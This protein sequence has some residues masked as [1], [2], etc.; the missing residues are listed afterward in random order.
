MT[1]SL[2]I[3]WRIFDPFNKNIVSSSI[4]SNR[5][6]D[7]WILLVRLNSSIWPAKLNLSIFI[8]FQLIRNTSI[9]CEYTTRVCCNLCCRTIFVFDCP[10]INEQSI[11]A[12]CPIYFWFLAELMILSSYG[13]SS[14]G[15]ALLGFFL[16]VDSYSPY[17]CIY[18]LGS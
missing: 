13:T 12:S 14:R 4:P 8:E 7:W 15:V 18:Y 17:L 1:L 6:L 2:S 5:I 3:A 10:V 9:N 16:W 11:L